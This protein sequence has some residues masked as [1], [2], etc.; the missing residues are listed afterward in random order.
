MRLTK[1]AIDS[2][3]AEPGQDRVFWDDEI[4]GFGIRVKPSGVKSFL[5]QYRNA[6]GRSRRLTVGK[7]GHLT[8][9][10]A[11]QAARRF[12]SD[13]DRGKDP[14]Q[15]RAEVRR[16]LTVKELGRRYLSEHA[17]PKKKLSSVRQDQRLLNKIIIPALGGRKVADVSK[18]D[19]A[20]LHHG[21]RQTP[22]QANRVLGLISK[23]MNLAEGWGL[24]P[25]GS[26]PC[27]YVERFKENKRKRYLNGQELARLGQ[28]LAEVEKEGSEL[29]SAILAIRL[30]IFT[31]ARLSEILSLRWEYV[32]AERGILNLPDSKTGA[33]LI[34]LNGPAAELLANA[35]RLMDSPYVIPGQWPDKPLVRLHTAW[36]RIRDRARLGDCRI[37]DLRHSYASVAAGAGLGLPLI[38]ALLGHHEAAT[39]QRYAHLALD[40]LKAAS[41][42][43][44]QQLAEAMNR[45]PGRKVLPLRPKR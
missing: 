20:K 35:P 12:L 30:L 29:P 36:W 24:R 34:P 28:T 16:G 44:G 7:Y 14:A 33:K 18:A 26:N 10:E 13:A 41:E 43:V 3:K 17:Q 2:L 11:R 23:M 25:D 32:D 6:Q 4:Q 27:R 21:L 37:H 19:M 45:R 15:A 38:G 40:P 8:P 39:T 31:G 1:R 5:V 22:V 9:A 42:L